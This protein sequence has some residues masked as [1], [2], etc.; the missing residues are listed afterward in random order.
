MGLISEYTAATAPGPIAITPDL[1]FG[2]H[3]HHGFHDD[4]HQTVLDHYGTLPVPGDMSGNISIGIN[5]SDIGCG[6]DDDDPYDDDD[7]DDDGD[8]DDDVN[9]RGRQHFDV[10]VG[11]DDQL[12]MHGAGDDLDE[13]DMAGME[14][15]SNEA[16]EHE[17]FEGDGDAGDNGAP[18]ART[19]A[20]TNLPHKKKTKS[21]QTNRKIKPVKRP[22]LVLKT[23]IAYQPCLDPS[24]IPIQRDGMGTFILFIFVL[25]SFTAIILFL[26][27]NISNTQILYFESMS[28]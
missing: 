15:N 17:D 28:S 9:D 24:V 27:F 7:D 19:A 20:S 12:M 3:P 1:T 11:N 8:N 10:G 21:T 22:G 25:F 5:V 13:D 4:H 14:D 16:L 26:I 18:V 2:H 23:P 6:D